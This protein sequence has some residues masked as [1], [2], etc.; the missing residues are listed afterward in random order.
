M[1]KHI[2]KIS[3]TFSISAKFDAVVRRGGGRMKLAIKREKFVRDVDN[4]FERARADYSSSLV[5]REIKRCD[6]SFAQ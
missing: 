2:K 5:T 1:E 6:F 3:A 4:I